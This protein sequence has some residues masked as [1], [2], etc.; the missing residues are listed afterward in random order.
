M[1]TLFSLHHV[2]KTFV[3]D[4]HHK[5]PVLQDITFDIKTG[6][7]F[8]IVGPSGSGKSTLLRIMSGLEK[9]Y[10]G[11]VQKDDSV[12]SAGFVFQQFGLLPWLTVYQNIELA[13]LSKRL[14]EHER[15]QIIEH[16]LQQFHLERFAHVHPHELSGGMS[17]RVGLARAFAIHPDIIF[18][19]EPFSELDLLRHMSSAKNYCRFGKNE[20]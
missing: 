2:H 18:L 19:D 14:P 11:L 1:K 10:E 17:Q 5:L 12:K 9:K 15:R 16:E 20:I 8:V 13:L 4:S 6:E 7:F 3:E